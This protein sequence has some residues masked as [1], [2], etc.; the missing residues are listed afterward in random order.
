VQK[1]GGINP[2]EG[3][4]GN[5]LTVPAVVG[6]CSSSS[7]SSSSSGSSSSSNSRHSMECITHACHSIAFLHFVTLWP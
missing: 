5:S 1:L 7:S 3:G 4:V 2:P 6:L